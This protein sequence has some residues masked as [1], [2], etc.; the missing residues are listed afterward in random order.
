MLW[1]F[2]EQSVITMKNNVPATDSCIICPQLS[3]TSWPGWCSPKR[4]APILP[5]KVP[6]PALLLRGRPARG[7]ATQ[8]QS[9]PLEPGVLEPITLK[10]SNVLESNRGRLDFWPCHILPAGGGGGLLNAQG[11]PVVRAHTLDTDQLQLQ[12]HPGDPGDVIEPPCGN[13][14]SKNSPIIGRRE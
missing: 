2:P 7:L 4:G 14:G 12:S 9:L 1:V 13:F 3:V 8:P 11:I 5:R 10:A 6:D